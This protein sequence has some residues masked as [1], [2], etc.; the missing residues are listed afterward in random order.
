M[1]AVTIQSEIISHKYGEKGLRR[2]DFTLAHLCVFMHS[3]IYVHEMM[4]SQLDK[5]QCAKN[6]GGFIYFHI[7]MCLFLQCDATHT[8]SSPLLPELEIH[9]RVIAHEHATCPR[10]T[11]LLISVHLIH[12]T[13]ILSVSPARASRHK[14]APPPG[15]WLDSKTPSPAQRDTIRQTTVQV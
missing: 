7:R 13:G 4:W 15:E 12:L 9:L 3:W 8:V 2:Q 5:S 10:S 1:A 14:H 6:C 11:H